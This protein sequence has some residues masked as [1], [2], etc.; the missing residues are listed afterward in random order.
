[1]KSSSL[2]LGSV[3]SQKHEVLL[4]LSKRRLQNFSIGMKRTH[5]PVYRRCGGNR[6]ACHGR[7]WVGCYGGLPVVS[8]A[9]LRKSRSSR[10][11]FDTMSPGPPQ[12]GATWLISTKKIIDALVDSVHVTKIEVMHSQRLARFRRRSNHF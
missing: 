9:K 5:G 3:P 6:T 4:I 11:R 8:R 2:Q 12:S 7:V 1:M 10:G